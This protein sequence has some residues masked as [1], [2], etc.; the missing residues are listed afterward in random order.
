MSICLRFVALPSFI[1][2]P[3]SR[4]GLH[5]RDQPSECMALRLLSAAALYLLI[6]RSLS[7]VMSEGYNIDGSY[8]LR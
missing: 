8:P 7:T 1:E 2:H 4:A 6:R 3:L 5:E